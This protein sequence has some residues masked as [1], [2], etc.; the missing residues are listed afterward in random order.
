MTECVTT[1]KSFLIKKEEEEE[2]QA[3]CVARVFPRDYYRHYYQ[4][5]YQRYYIIIIII[6]SNINI[7][8]SG[9]SNVELISVSLSDSVKC[10]RIERIV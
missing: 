7:S 5:Y 4:Q 8:Q 1:V 10:A 6:S 3:G 9:K 2:I